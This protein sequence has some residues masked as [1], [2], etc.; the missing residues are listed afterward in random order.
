MRI[1]F[2][3]WDLTRVPTVPSVLQREEAVR[4]SVSLALI[5][6]LARE[7]TPGLKHGQS[8]PDRTEIYELLGGSPPVIRVM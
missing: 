1:N 5:N 7:E 6:V 2:F 3:C 8:T 4:L